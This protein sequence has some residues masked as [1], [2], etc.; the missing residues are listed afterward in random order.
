MFTLQSCEVSSSKVSSPDEQITANFHLSNKGE[1][2]YTISYKNESIIDTSYIGFEFTNAPALKEGFIARV[3]KPE[4]FNET[5]EMPWGEQATVV[6]HYNEVVVELE[7]KYD[8][9]RKVNIVFIIL[10]T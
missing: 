6:N 7:E 3:R 5:W 1:F 9:Q 8:L 4:E 10:D 2:F